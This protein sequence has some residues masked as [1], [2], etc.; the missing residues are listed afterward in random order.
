MIRTLTAAFVL[1]AGLN[2]ALSAEPPKDGEKPANEP[3]KDAKP[4]APPKKKGGWNETTDEP[5]K[6]IDLAKAKE[7]P[8][9]KLNLEGFFEAKRN[10]NESNSKGLLR[11]RE[12]LKKR[13]ETVIAQRV[14]GT[15]PKL[16]SWPLLDGGRLDLD[17][18]KGKKIVVL[19]FWALP[20]VDCVEPLP[21]WADIAKAYKDQPVEVYAVLFHRAEEPVLRK[22]LNQQEFKL[23]VAIGPNTFG[24]S[25]AFGIDHRMP[26]TYVIGMDGKTKAVHLILDKELVP[27]VSKELDLLLAGKEL[28]APAAGPVA[29]APAKDGAKKTEK[30]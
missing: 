9:Y 4:E 11:L 28:P 20:C 16:R 23:P 10:V 15:E 21:F 24:P 2:A 1:A 8:G 18:L 3:G 25:G 19:G 22:F 27:T 12:G 5:N 29:E 30:E 14:V 13:T 6:A 17:A 7:Y 26:L